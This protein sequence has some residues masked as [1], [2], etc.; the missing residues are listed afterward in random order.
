MYDYH[1]YTITC[2][3]KDIKSVYVGSTYNWDHR[4]ETHTSDSKKKNTKL[5]KY[6]RENGGIINWEMEEIGFQPGLTP[7]EAHIIEE[8]YRELYCAELNTYRCHLTKDQGKQY[9]REYQATYMPMYRE[10]HKDYYKEY[11]KNYYENNKEEICTY[12]QT[13]RDS[14]KLERA[15]Y[16]TKRRQEDPKYKALINSKR[17]CPICNKQ[18]RYG[19]LSKHIKT[20]HDLKV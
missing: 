11:N 17:P 2:K 9:R 20:Q 18:I 8:L 4:V 12:A 3:D 6:I 14:H 1:F 7:T 10:K 5:Y 16:D 13:Y 19:N 15:A